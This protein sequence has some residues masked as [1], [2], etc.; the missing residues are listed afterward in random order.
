MSTQSHFKL[1]ILYTKEQASEGD[2]WLCILCN[3]LYNVA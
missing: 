1:R 3:M 2:I